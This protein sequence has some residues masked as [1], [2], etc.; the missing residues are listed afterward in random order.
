MFFRR[1]KKKRVCVIG[2]DGVPFS[3]LLDLKEK[4]VIPALSRIIDSGHLQRMKASLPEISAVSWTDFMTGKNSGSHGI[5][6]FTDL[7]PNSYELRFPNFFDLKSD[8]FWDILGRKKKKTIVINQ[9]STYPARKVNGALISGF[10]AIELAKSVFPPSLLPPLRK[11]GYKIDIDTTK[12]RDNHQI[13]WKELDETLEGREKAFELLWKDDWDYFEFVITG[14]DRLHHFLWSAYE[15]ED[16]PYHNNFL[17]YYRKIDELVEK[18]VTGFRKMTD[19]EGSLF[20]LSDHG[21][22]GI[23]E[24]VY[25]NVWL[26]KNGYL[27]LEDSS[28]GSLTSISPE[29][30]AFVLDPNRI[31]FNFKGKYPRGCVGANDIKPLKEEI[32]AGLEEL[33]YKGKKVIK[34]IFE[35]EE[36]YS[37]PLI[38]LGPDLLVIPEYGFDMK[39]SLKK[40]EL[41][42]RTVLQGMHT[43]DDAFFWSKED[44]GHDLSIS[45][46]AG[47]ILESLFPE[48]LP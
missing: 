11:A 35:A 31:Y 23:V 15:E 42:G 40:K 26:E 44:Y 46:L 24:E 1:K 14:T 7:K 8:T 12:S 4:G 28:S 16:H 33:E 25:L 48:P 13:L 36:V 6:G 39:G 30:R 43:W 3:L 27:S 34:K 18:I 38:S 41:F 17:G 29:S 32:K 45:Q 2:L 5:F 21:F 9:P 22:T 19:D 10:V 20:L 47:F 37:G